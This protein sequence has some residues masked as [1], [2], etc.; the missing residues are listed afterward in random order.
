M[1][2]D[3]IAA[4]EEKES[5]ELKQRNVNR[6]LE[7]ENRDVKF[8]SDAKDSRI[9]Q[10]E[11]EL[12]RLKGKLQHTLEKIY[13]PTAER[14]MDALGKVD[15][16]SANNLVQGHEQAMEVNGGLQQRTQNPALANAGVREQEGRL[17]ERA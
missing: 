17:D 6:Q 12:A 8:L 9:R 3:I 16:E 1:H 11:Q 2:L 5:Q 13:M 10:L 14:A 15:G 7:D 4:R